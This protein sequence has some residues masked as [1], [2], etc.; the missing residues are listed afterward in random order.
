VKFL[1][2]TNVL[3]Q[4]E[5]TA[6]SDFEPGTNA[7]FEFARR[8]SESGGQ[9]YVHPAA[10]DDIERDKDEERRKLRLTVLNRYSSLPNPP[11]L[12]TQLEKVLGRAA[13]HSNDWVDNLLLAALNADAVD[14]LVTEDNKIRAK[15][16]RLSLD[17][18]VATVAEA[19]SL[20]RDLFDKVPPPPPAVERVSAHCLDE[21]DPIFGSFRLD[22]PN[23]DEWLKKCKRKQRSALVI[24]GD[25][26][27]LAALCIY[28][29][30]ELPSFGLTG[31]VLKICS[32]KVSGD[33]NGFRYGELLLK[34]V[35][36]YASSNNYDWVF[37]T[38]FEKYRNLIVLLEE[39]GFQSA[40]EM[41]S[42]GELVLTKPMSFTETERQS[43]DPLS[44]NTRYGPSAMKLMGVPTFIVPI[45]PQYHRLLFPEGKGQLDL[46][47]GK[48]PFG[49][50]IR[51]A[52]L[53]NA[54]I[55]GITRGSNLLFYRSED[56]RGVT[57]LG[58]VEETMV[59][60]SPDKIAGYVGKRT[61]YTFR[62]ID[63]LCAREVLAI[64][65]RQSRILDRPISLGELKDK[66]VVS[67]APQS[68]GSVPE[69]TLEWLQ[70]RL[71]G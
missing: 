13:R 63:A 34:S 45:R 37:V 53:S 65:F 52:Y 21:T 28:K 9:L 48:H 19:V 35:F 49:N 3:I 41:T 68:I 50:S 62:E 25:C 12:S 23:F 58:I 61:V 5:P 31:K 64:L 1:I 15:A 59:S 22:Y 43:L 47:A 17:T 54:S 32:F 26:S 40:E 24:H 29:H 27:T 44:F 69:R 55:R 51:K 39:F 42:L 56:V 36:D 10:R 71:D 7:V 4:L 30:E 11:A 70:T 33:Y 14:V 38:V 16:T 66:G 6:I 46:M 57:C 60:S 20:V 18:R 2:D 8:V 67:A